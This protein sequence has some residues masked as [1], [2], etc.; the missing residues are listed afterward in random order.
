[1]TGF[2]QLLLCQCVT[3]V[4]I[5]PE[6]RTIPESLMLIHDSDFKGIGIDSTFDWNR[7]QKMEAWN[8]NHEFGNK[9]HPYMK[10]VNG[11]TVC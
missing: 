9:A 4:T 7:N 11:D 8:R 10:G 2:I 5:T 6:K 1:M 3:L